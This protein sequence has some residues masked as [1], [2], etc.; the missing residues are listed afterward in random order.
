MVLILITGTIGTK[1]KVQTK[2][3]AIDLADKNVSF[4]ELESAIQGIEVGVLGKHVSYLCSDRIVIDYWLALWIIVNNAGVSH[5]MPVPFAQ[6]PD[7]ELSNI[8]QVVRFSF[9]SSTDSRELRFSSPS[10][11]RTSTRPSPSPRSFSPR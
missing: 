6:T 5:H 2:F 3:V 9:P 1:Y 7:Q 11:S 8:L 10:S 4:A